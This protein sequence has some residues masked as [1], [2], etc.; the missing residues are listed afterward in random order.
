[1]TSRII[2]QFSPAWAHRAR[3]PFIYLGCP[4]TSPDTELQQTRVEVASIVAAELAVSNHAVFSP[5]THGHSMAQHL[6]G[7]TATSTHQFWMGQCLPI[8]AAADEL[9]V[10]PLD[11]WE[12]SR[13][14]E[15]ELVFAQD[16]GIPIKFI[17]RLREPWN[18]Y[19]GEFEA[20]AEAIKR[21]EQA[22]VVTLQAQTWPGVTP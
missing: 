4:Y 22:E 10:L 6:P 2:R 1:M 20:S 12:Q 3:H 8:L 11:G 5:I 21:W 16:H 17:M 18:R 9:W 19:L 14:L 15:E 13:G 7:G